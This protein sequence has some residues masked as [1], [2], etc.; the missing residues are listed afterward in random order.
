MIQYG[1]MSLYRWNE[2]RK[3]QLNPLCARQVIHSERMT[4]ARLYLAKGAIVPEH[5][6]ENEQ[7]T[8]VEQGRLKMVLNGVE[9]LMEAAQ[10]VVI[11]PNVPHWVEAL[12]DTVAVD[13]FSPG[14]EDWKRGDDAYLRK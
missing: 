10:S 1:A 7:I 13:V 2:I 9:T 4:V 3:E 14:R 8:T 11:P 5:H 6:H 12:E